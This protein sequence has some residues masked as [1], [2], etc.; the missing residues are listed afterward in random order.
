MKELYLRDSTFAHCAFSNNP[1]P[2]KTF[3]KYISWNRNPG[4]PSQTIYTE[5]HI[6][7]CDGG[8]GWLI[9]PYDLM[10]HNYD[11]VL[12]NHN[13]FKQIWTHERLLTDRLAN[14][15]F[16]PFGGCWIDAPDYKVHPKTKMF[17]IIASGKRVLTGHN[18]RHRIIEDS[19]GKIDTF[20]N[21]YTYIKDKI[22]GLKDYRYHFTIENCKRDYWFT[23]KLIDCF[24]TG[25]IPIYWGC[26]SIGKFFNTNG[27][28]IFDNLN[29]L[30]E[31]LKICS[32]EH[33]NSQIFA[34]RD[35]FVRAQKYVLAEDWIYEKGLV[36]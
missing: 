10:P 14:A 28:I 15:K 19:E 12:N 32:E 31:K 16:V 36:K 9:E 29:D 8:I 34:V 27:M 23:E 30:K 5:N 13:K 6:Q 1:M 26:P 20:G 21:G 33:Y 4:L 3:S 35:N 17:S 25:T 24:I 7:E 2:P 11:Y 18:L 22:E